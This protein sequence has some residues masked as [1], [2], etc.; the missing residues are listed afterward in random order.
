[1]VVKHGK[2]PNR[3]WTIDHERFILREVNRGREEYRYKSTRH[4]IAVSRMTVC[5]ETLSAGG[6]PRHGWSYTS[7]LDCYLKG[8][9]VSTIFDRRD[10]IITDPQ[11]RPDGL[12]RRRNPPDQKD[13]RDNTTI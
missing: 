5:L 1:M 13:Q 8:F 3:D 9:F 6:E 4:F 10:E 7:W 2:V 11:R 12:Q